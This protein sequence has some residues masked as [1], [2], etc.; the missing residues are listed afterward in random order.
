M[1]KKILFNKYKQSQIGSES[2]TETSDGACSLVFN[3]KKNKWT[4]PMN[5]A[6][7]SV[8]AAGPCVFSS[9]N[10]PEHTNGIRYTNDFCKQ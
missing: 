3:M 7:V 6:P 8:S 1:S 9:E 4:Q 5:T 2:S 10:K